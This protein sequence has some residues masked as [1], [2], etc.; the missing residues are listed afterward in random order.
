MEDAMQLTFQKCPSCGDWI[1]HH[2]RGRN[3]SGIRTCLLK[4]IEIH[5]VERD[6]CHL[7][8]SPEWWTCQGVIENAK[9]GLRSL[10]YAVSK[11]YSDLERRFGG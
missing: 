10:D 3:A 5:E 8:N 6:E 4:R 9:A 11:F 7:E 2:E 1:R